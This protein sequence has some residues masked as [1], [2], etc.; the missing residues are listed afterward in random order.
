MTVRDRAAFK[1][2][3]TDKTMLLTIE[4]KLSS[5]PASVYGQ[6]PPLERVRAKCVGVDEIL[7][8]LGSDDRAVE[9]I[10]GGCGQPR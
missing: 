9:N 6:V 8:M 4:V 1:C 3:P 2:L 7:G 10:G 5:V